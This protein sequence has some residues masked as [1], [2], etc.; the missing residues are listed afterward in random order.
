MLAISSVAQAGRIS[1][2]PR[3][4]SMRSPF[5]RIA[6]RCAPR[7]TNATSHPEPRQRGAVDRADA[8]GADNRDPH[9]SLRPK[10]VVHPR[11]RYSRLN[12]SDQPRRR[13][14][15]AS[16]D[17]A[18]PRSHPRHRAETRR[19]FRHRDLRRGLG[20]PRPVEARPQP[21]YGG[22]IA[23]AR[24]REAARRASRAR[25]A[26]RRHQGRDRRIDHAS[27]L[28]RRL[29]GGDDRGAGRQ[30]R[31][32]EEPRKPS[33]TDGASGRYQIRRPRSIRGVSRA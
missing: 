33:G 8:A 17:L 20:A 22:D 2:S 11:R 6:A 7:A 25:L 9:R 4:P 23:R 5:S 10:A 3:S 12:A 1:V 31:L 24:P 32:R 29:A 27:G 18:G 30:G 16:T 26:E 14:M 15:P 13:D 19:D 21:D 28:L